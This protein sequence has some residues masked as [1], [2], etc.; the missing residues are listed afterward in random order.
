MELIIESGATK[1]DYCLYGAEGAVDRC[2]GAGINFATMD[3]D[4]VSP[5]FRDAVSLLNAGTGHGDAWRQ[6]VSAVYF[7]GAGL[8]GR[9]DALEGL[10]HEAFPR[11]VTECRSDLMAAARAVCGDE[12]GLVAILGTG[13]N[14]CL[15]DGS[16]IV[17]NIRP[18][19]YVLGDFGSGAALGKQFLADYLQ[20]LMPEALAEDF[21]G[22]YG[23]DYASAVESVYR[24][25]SP[26]RYLASFAPYI[27]A[28]GR[29]SG[30]LGAA[31]EAY[32]SA[33]VEEN[34]RLFM[35]RC[36]KPYGPEYCS[37]GVVGS[38]GCACM[39]TLEK[40]ASEFGISVSRFMPSPMDG[41]V[42]YHLMNKRKRSGGK[43]VQ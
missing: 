18:C 22:K 21:R 27:V 42:E 7:Y 17:K 2:Q 33:L 28:A 11:A 1:T 31:S 4:T 24:G 25:G 35:R 32:A 23:I 16:R 10:V 40:V 15:Y 41:L 14:S 9:S 26:A 3:M 38:F 12:P 6:D 8:T 20:G 43:D 36:I 29:H 5:V 39:G 37:M 19:G 13:S 30:R 34:F